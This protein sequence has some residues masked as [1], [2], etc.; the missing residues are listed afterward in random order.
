[1]KQ[2]MKL[3]TKM[4]LGFGAVALI[5]LIVGIVGYYGAV[6]GEHSVEEIG[7]VRLP[8]VDSLLVIKGEAQQIRGTMRTL[9]IPGLAREVR[10]RQ[11]QNL[12]TSRQAYEAAWNVYEPLPQTDEEA[13]VWQQFVPAWNNWR[14]ENNKLMEIVKQFDKLEMADPMLMGRQ[15][16]SFTKDHFFW[17]SR[18]SP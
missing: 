9:V 4:M 1:M 17:W 5:T 15:V 18:S 12:V 13:R 10:E 16:E 6:K 11:Y 2:Q 8:S 3:G 14:A 7:G